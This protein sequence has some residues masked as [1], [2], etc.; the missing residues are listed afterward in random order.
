[1]SSEQTLDPRWVRALIRREQLALVGR[2][3][4]GLRHNIS[5]AVQM[6]R[7]PLDLMEMQLLQGKA[8][9]MTTKLD[10]LK[11][12]ALR[13]DQELD[14]LSEKSIQLQRTGP[15]VFDLFQMAHQQLDFWR[16]DM[17]YKHDVDLRLELAS[18][19]AL[20]QA[21]YQD[22]AL[23]FNCL[24][25]NA[26]EAL[27]ASEKRGLSLRS[28]LGPE[29]PWLVVADEAGGPTPEIRP[30]MFEPFVT[31]KGEEHDGL[32]LFLAQE[33]LAPWQGRLEWVE[34]PLAGFR[35]SLPPA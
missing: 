3:L 17:F 4:Q 12:G 28:G 25:I 31:D 10:A 27:R 6:I 8:L 15:E 23:A 7:L 34:E 26:L 19:S 32:G 24:V 11:K 22:V 13:L 20:V 21:A 5:G 29:G 33:A 18:D 2:L 9:D 30:R 14:L 16:A 1:V 35:L